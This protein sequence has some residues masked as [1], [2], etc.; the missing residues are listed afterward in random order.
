[1]NQEADP[2]QLLHLPVLMLDLQPPELQ[3][4]NF[5]YLSFPVCSSLLYQ[6]LVHPPKE[7]NKYAVLMYALDKPASRCT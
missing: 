6:E 4:I 3:T 1:M 5:C 7:I 2:H